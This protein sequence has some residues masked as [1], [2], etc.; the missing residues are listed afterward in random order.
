M[1]THR[2]FIAAELPQPVKQALAGAQ[3]Q[4]RRA[5]SPVKWVAVEAMHLTLRFLGETDAGLV[6]R[7]GAALREALND[8]PAITLHLTTAGAFPNLR[9]PNVVWAGIGGSTVALA[10]AHTAM[11]AALAELEIPGEQRPF[12]AHLTLGR[13]RRDATPAQ[14][15]RLGEAIRAL[16]P[17]TPAPWSVG[18]VV[19][20]RSELRRD[21]PI[22]TELDAVTLR[23]DQMTR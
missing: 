21:G 19:L 5:G 11:E 1:E 4:L 22:Y 13:V 8:L 17:F 14:Q 20:F 18:R 10:H 6:P 16:P 9:R 3:E 12:R 2:L 15:E 23:D 7:L